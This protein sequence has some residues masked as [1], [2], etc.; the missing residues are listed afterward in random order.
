MNDA[1]IFQNKTKSRIP[2]EGFWTPSYWFLLNELEVRNTILLY[3][4]WS[5]IARNEQYAMVKCTQEITQ[6][7]ETISNKEQ[8]KVKRNK[9]QEQEGNRKHKYLFR[10]SSHRSTP[11][12]HRR[13]GFPLSTEDFT[14]VY[15]R[16]EYRT[17]TTY[18]PPPKRYFHKSN[19]KNK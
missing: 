6:V 13:E 17:P 9:G 16:P 12:L 1:T 8:L 19:K 2:C 11:R 5:T 14:M 3:E 15:R 18:K 10:G 4:N 7:K